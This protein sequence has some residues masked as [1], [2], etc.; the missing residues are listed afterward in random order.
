MRTNKI[1]YNI[2]TDSELVDN[3]YSV[4]PQLSTLIHRY[5]QMALEGKK[6]SIPKLLSAIEKYPQNPQLK[7][8][9]SVL[10][11]QLEEHQKMYDVNKWIIAEHPNYLFGKLNLANQYYLNQEYDKMPDV[12]GHEMELKSLYP[13]RETFHLNEFTSFYKCAILYFVATGNIEQAEIRYDLMKELA[14]DSSDTE[15]VVLHLFEARMKA[16]QKRYEKEQET[17]VS[18]ETKSQEINS[19]T[20]SPNFHHQEIEE[21]YRI[22]LYIEKEKIESILS[23]PRQ[24]LIK[25]L[26]LILKDSIIRYSYFEKMLDDEGWVEDRMSFLIHAFF[27]LGELSASESLNCIF[28]VLSQSDEYCELYFGDFLT[29]VLWEP[30]LKFGGNNLEACK[31]FMFKSG[32]QTYV[33]GAILSAVEQIALHQPA[34]RKEAIKWFNEVLEFYLSCSLDQNI[35]DSEVIAF[36]ICALIDIEGAELLPQIERA[37][38]RGIVSTMVCGPLSEVKEAFEETKMYT[39]KKDILS[40]FDRYDA[41]T[42]SWVGYNEEERYPDIDYSKQ[43]DSNLKPIIVGSKI[44]RNEPCPCGSGKKYKKCCLNN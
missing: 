35:I 27:F 20:Q 40:I 14:P 10:Y 2:T 8:Y 41:I 33:R 7:N 44:G 43:F 32:I 36:M 17:K 23:L 38:D 22:G 34:R 16:S 3:Q 24:T 6:S 19:I 31:E 1:S 28:E 26:E 12:L 15:M 11:N 9:L 13:D 42:S 30:I 5:H 25:D 37:F 21:L 39:V 18:V 4:T 29:E